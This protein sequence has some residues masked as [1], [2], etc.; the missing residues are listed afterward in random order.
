MVTR[1]SDQELL[2]VLRGVAD[3]FAQV[4]IA[5]PADRESIWPMVISALPNPT[6]R[7]L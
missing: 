4:S 7:Q 5:R 2:A 6:G 1:V 3:H